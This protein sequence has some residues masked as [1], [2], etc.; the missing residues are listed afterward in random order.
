MSAKDLII[1]NAR[2]TTLDRQNPS[3]EALAIR[4]GRFLAVGSEAEAR[5][6]APEATVIDAKAIRM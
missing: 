2:I 4:D 1:V 5:A 3:A 6:A